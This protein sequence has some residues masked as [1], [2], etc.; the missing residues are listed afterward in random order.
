MP[1]QTS[2]SWPNIL[3]SNFF[4]GEPQKQTYLGTQQSRE[5]VLIIKLMLPYL[6]RGKDL[7]RL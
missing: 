4:M 6:G 7:I 3:S 1:L 5:S 2:S